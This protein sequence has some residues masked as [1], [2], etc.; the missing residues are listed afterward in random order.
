MPD[1][2]IF[3]R[4]D[5]IGDLILNLPVDQ[6]PVLKNEQ[7]HWF[8][9][10]GLSWITEYA[11]PGRTVTEFDKNFSFSN[12]CEMVKKFRQ[13][14]PT[15]VVIFY[16]PGWVMF[17]AWLARVPIRC[18]RLSQWYSFL[19]L[20][21]GLRQSRSQ[22]EKHELNYNMDLVEKLIDLPQTNRANGKATT[23]HTKSLYLQM[24]APSDLPKNFFW[25][26]YVVIHPGMAG[27]ALNWPTE[28]YS[29]LIQTLTRDLKQNVVVTGTRNDALYIE[30]LRQLEFDNE[31]VQ[32]WNEKLSSKDLLAVLQKAKAVVGPSTGVMHLAASLGVRSI[33]LYSPIQSQSAVRWRPLGPKVSVLQGRWNN[34]NENFQ[35]ATGTE[36]N[37]MTNIT[38]QDVVKEI[39]QW[40]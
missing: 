39:E 16:A 30:P 10:R 33:G 13:L 2:T 3:I 32:W 21:K 19:L 8:I 27:S 1:K 36:N 5:K 34:S 24:V 9:S 37:P 17:A 40:Q 25:Q 11:R 18:G 31:K 28:Y 23:D 38:V 35:Q 4:M 14:K 7:I 20:N 22:S 29:E 6:H 15:Q 12:F 26:E